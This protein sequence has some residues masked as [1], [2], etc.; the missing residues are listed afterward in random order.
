[1]WLL[2]KLVLGQHRIVL[3]QQTIYRAQNSVFN[4]N[5]RNFDAN[6]LNNKQS[7]FYT[8]EKKQ[9]IKLFTL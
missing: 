5:F 4:P 1:M 6:K 8:D 3:A 9:K 2:Q 7:A